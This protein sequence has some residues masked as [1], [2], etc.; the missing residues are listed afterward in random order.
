MPK[1]AWRWL[2]AITLLMPATGVAL[3]RVMQQ[4]EQ[5]E[6]PAGSVIRGTLFVFCQ[7]LSI[8][9]RVDGNVI[10]FGLRTVISGEVGKN[11]YMAGLEYMVT[12]AISGDLHFVGATLDVRAPAAAGPGP[13]GG[14]IIFAAL[15]AQISD[16]AA[17]AGPITGVGYQLKLDGRAR[18]EINYWGSAFYLQGD[19]TGDVYAAVGNPDS[20]VSD[21]ETLLLPLE[22]ELNFLQPGLVI[23]EG[24]QIGGRLEYTGPAAGRID[25]GVSGGITY[26]PTALA[27]LPALP[28]AGLGAIFAD[29]FQREFAALMT[30]GLLGLVFLPRQF[31][32]ALRPI[33]WRPV[34]SFVI[35]MLSFILS[36]PV[37]LLLLL[38][39]SLLLLVLALLRLEGVLLVAGA[40]LALVNISVTGFFYFTAIFI[41][42]AVFALGLGRLVIQ[43]IFGLDAAIRA[44]RLSLVVGVAML[45]LL[46]SLPIVG[47][48]FNAGALFVGLGAIATVTLLRIDRARRSNHPLRQD[49]GGPRRLP[50][51]ELAPPGPEGAQRKT[52]AALLKSATG[53]A[54]GLSN[55]PKGF[56]ADS[57]FTDD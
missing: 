49:M 3:A 55:L 21:L 44:P 23:A 8:A 37:A 28:D 51:A 29:Q 22:L 31:Q 52:A 18:D 15:S 4:G 19:V 36:F 34:Q 56:D 48:A 13:V 16:R 6:V 41:A 30:A 20:G 17:L 26:Q 35:G 10:G 11:V 40:G 5:C 9:G 24:A 7:H 45:S 33:R 42:R 14:Q 50:Q 47:F 43:L 46:V 38:I 2:I 1:A 12:G 54:P 25:G 57:F 39:S 53:R 27:T 32:S